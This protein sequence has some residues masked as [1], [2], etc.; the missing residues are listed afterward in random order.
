MLKLLR[1]A[2]WVKNVFVLLPVFIGGEI[3]DWAA[4]GAALITFGLFCLTSSA[5]YCINDVVDAPYDAMH[6]VKCNR[7]I[8]SGKIKPSE[9]IMIAVSLL[10]VVG[11]CIVLIPIST[12]RS[13][14]LPL[15][16]YFITNLGYSLY[17]KRLPVIDVILI[18]CFFL[19]RIWAGA[20]A[21]QIELTIWTLLLV[22]LLTLLLA[23]GKRR[24]EAWLCEKQG[25]MSRSN[26][27]SYN[28][29]FLN[30]MLVVICVASVVVYFI[31]TESSYV[32]S[33]YHNRFIPLTT[34]LVVAGLWRYLWLL[35]RKEEG[36]NP[37]D[38]VLKDR[39]LQLIIISWI[40]CFGFILY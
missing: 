10:L 23:V 16:I 24:H 1:P 8:A 28:V 37:T 29:R 39:V 13:V 11:L 19:L 6:P 40:I 36:G 34:L 3:G 18:A 22:F 31:W 2:Q 4:L 7:P 5:V 15:G 38:L 27:K 32:V 21:G 20:I 17:L 12:I 9:G 25:I 30:R 26:I 33:R 35:F 14:W